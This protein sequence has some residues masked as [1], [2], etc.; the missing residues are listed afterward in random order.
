[1]DTINT[2][3]QDKAREDL[4]LKPRKVTTRKCLRCDVVFISNA[5]Q[6]RC[7]KCREAGRN[8]G[9]EMI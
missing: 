2:Q 8:S 6:R 4:G 7:E 3:Q 1:M 9:W 5:E